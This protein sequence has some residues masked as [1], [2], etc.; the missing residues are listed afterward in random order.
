MNITED[1]QQPQQVQLYDEVTLKNM[2]RWYDQQI[3]LAEKSKDL[4]ELKAS[5]AK[6]RVEETYALVQMARITAPA[7]E[8]GQPSQ[9][10]EKDTASRKGSPS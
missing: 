1:N 2:T 6:A 9:E 8:S 5:I 10:Q 3:T 7:P 4:A